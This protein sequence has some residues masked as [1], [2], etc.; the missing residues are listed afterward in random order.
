MIE[1]RVANAMKV[2][3]GR[4]IGDNTGKTKRTLKCSAKNK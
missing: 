1:Y 2:Q 4:G 3:A